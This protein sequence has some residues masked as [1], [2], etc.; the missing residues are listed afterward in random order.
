MFARSQL[1]EPTVF[2]SFDKSED[3]LTD[4]DNAE[5]IEQMGGVKR[6]IVSLEEMSPLLIEGFI[7]VEDQRF[8]EHQ[9]VDY[10][11]TILAAINYLFGKGKKFGASTITQQV[12]KNISGDNQQTLKRKLSEILRA[13]NIERKY[14]KEEIL[15]LYMNTVPMGNNRYG[16]AA[17]S[18]AYFGKAP[19]ELTAAEAA[20]LVGIVNAPSLYN[21]YRNSDACIKK[22]NKVLSVMRSTGVINESEYSEAVL[23]ELSLVPL[24]NDGTDINSWFIEACI[25]DLCADLSKK[26]SVSESAAMLM[27][28]GGGY[29]VYTTMDREI[30]STL[31]DYFSDSDNLPAE[32]DNGL[33][34]SMVVTDS[35][36]G[37]VVGIIGGVGRKSA[38]RLFNNAT[39]P[40]PPA[41]TLKPLAIYAPLIDKGYINWSTVIDDTPE[42]VGTSSMY[43]HNS[44][45]VYNGLTTVK[46]AIR[47][48]KNTVAVKLARKL[49]VKA[50]FNTLQESYGFTTLV[51]DRTDKD[52]KRF[53]D[54]AVS[55]M[56]L[57][58]LTDGISLVSLTEAYT[59][60][61]AGGVWRNGR[62]YYC[63]K[64]SSGKV[65]INKPSE[66]KRIM[67]ETT[68]NIMN[69][70]LMA[71]TDSGTAKKI[72]LKDHI[73]TAG[74]TGTSSGNRDKLFVGYTPY[75]TAGIWCGYNEGGRGVGGLSKSHLQIWD[76]IMLKIH[77]QFINTDSKEQFST[78]GLIKCGYCMDSGEMY[79]ERCKYD[80]RY[81]RMEYGYFTP[82]NKPKLEC[83]RHVLV[84]YDSVS[85]GI[86]D[87]SC[88]LENRVKVALINIPER[89]FI[90]QI[91]ITDAEYVYR[92]CDIT[93]QRPTDQSLPYF[94]YALPDEEYC[95]I[96]GSKKQFNAAGRVYE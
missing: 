83:Q 24:E 28:Q 73:D 80:P 8:F 50:I 88:P 75:Y 30:Q 26:Y 74:K 22:R 1:W 85:K 4:F 35:R 56:A 79:T 61:A 19:D 11:R 7:S 91:L 14:T 31:N 94:Y 69:Q 33:N 16:I 90:R 66:Q 32:V 2:Y 53:T 20:T 6:R 47:L 49:G 25:S 52:G 70:L 17:A 93:F 71:V 48:S 60:F 87:P 39:A 5:K 43:P 76:E 46:D 59:A 58:Q 77:A 96:T 67:K 78:D 38:N 81:S 9:G 29:S 54:I 12:I 45:D 42:Y 82:D 23:S 84:D 36:T 55:P 34:Y 68:A 51:E 3:G 44:P 10:K 62:T 57:G 65:V 72:K 18:S 37:D 92:E 86:I 63:V 95:G 64:D 21:P 27:L 40:H 13:I 89:R 15:E 41:S